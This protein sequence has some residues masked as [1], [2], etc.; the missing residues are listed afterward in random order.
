MQAKRVLVV[1][2]GSAGWISAAY[3]NA[4]L[5]RA[6]QGAVEVTLVESP[7][8][9]RIGVGEATV[10]T[11]R[12]ILQTVGIDE[13][14]F[15]READATFKQAIKFVNWLRPDGHA[16]YHPFDRRGSGPVDWAAH[17]WL[18]SDRSVPFA[19]TVSVQPQL[20][21]L[22]LAP[23]M[24]D[25]KDFASPMPY[26][27]HMDADKFAATLCAHATT[28]GVKHV[29][30]DVVRVERHPD[31]AIAAVHTH[32]GTR[33]EADLFIDCTGF[34]GLLIE[35][36]LGVPSRDFSPWLLC[37]RAIAMRV[38]YDAHYP[39]SIR[40]YTTATAL[41]S[42]WV[43]DIGLVNRRGT[44]YVYSSE[45]IDDDK[46]EA[47]LRA[48]EG[49]HS[50]ELDARRIRFN[51]GCRERFWEKNCIAIG[52]SGGFIEPLESTGLYLSEFAA[53]T[54]AEHFPFGD[55]IQ[56][57]ADRFNRILSNRYNEVL[58]FVNMHYALSR[59]DDTP[60]WREVQR[61][62]RI[63][64]S[65]K[66][67]LE[68]WKIKPPSASDFDDQFRLFSHQSYEY[69]LYG[70]DFLQGAYLERFAGRQ[71]ESR[72]PQHIAKVVEAA[73]TRLPRHEDWLGV[74]G[75]GTQVA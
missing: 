41:S 1:G 46:A 70:M 51:V 48:H 47:E 69:I 61:S 45:F 20:C 44:G 74:R 2:G 73:K 33:L 30:D 12:H 9:A 62:E 56:P 21:E 15:L 19:D 66:E 7:N 26:A 64:D 16:Y 28:Q 24:H 25:S 57:L 38:P 31:G 6:G 36:E 72:I 50:S 40:P 58:D 55:T 32:R 5:N 39:G 18:A 65:L 10:P 13:S 27:Y 8:I 14:R 37:D 68:F 63:T 60:F 29:L 53:V 34:R 75:P 59:R 22:G 49:A 71:P 35:G 54:L 17:T 52:L 42:G 4:A 67:K 23:R 11:V 43:W 3:L